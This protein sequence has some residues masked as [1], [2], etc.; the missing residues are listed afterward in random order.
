M[1]VTLN[2]KPIVEAEIPQKATTEDPA[3]Q[4]YVRTVIAEAVKRQ[5]LPLSPEE[6]RR[7]DQAAIDL[8]NQW[9]EEDKTG[10]PEEMARRQAEWE[11]FKVGMNAAHTS[12]RI[13]YL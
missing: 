3:L 7:K 8:L 10:D 2:P 12:D 6:Q 4:E 13:L 1:T 11:E 9:D 5:S